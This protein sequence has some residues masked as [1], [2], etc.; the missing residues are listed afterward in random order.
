YHTT[1][2]AREEKN[3]EN[4]VDVITDDNL[5]IDQKK[6]R[7]WKMKIWL[8]E[9]EQQFE[10]PNLR[11]PNYIAGTHPFP[12]NPLF[13]PQPPVSDEVREEIYRL[14]TDHQLTPRDIA[15]KYGISIKR[16]EAI[17]KL[18][19]EEKRL[20]KKGVVLQQDL[21]N[22][23]E[24][25]LGVRIF[26]RSVEPLS[27]IIPKVKKPRFQLIEE[28]SKFTPEDAARILGREPLEQIQQRQLE[29]EHLNPFSLDD[30]KKKDT[31]R[32]IKKDNC[33]TNKRFK[34]IFVDTEKKKT[35]IREQDG[36]LLQ[37]VDVESDMAIANKNSRTGS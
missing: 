31:F 12:M 19:D 36:T 26:A 21:R 37:K 15:D 1:R 30:T 34:F 6:P 23:M 3:I 8:Q 20:V 5:E 11:G 33:E 14:F 35:L 7:R 2:I 18:K 24:K 28:G 25:M 16:T 13:K 17:L 27:T 9:Q 22:N 10:T 4:V 29:Y 32:T